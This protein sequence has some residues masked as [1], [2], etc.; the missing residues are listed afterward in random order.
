MLHISAPEMAKNKNK[1]T[2]K[3]VL[4]T[5]KCSSCSLLSAGAIGNFTATVAFCWRAPWLLIRD[6][7]IDGNG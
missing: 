6:G 5:V 7:K 2:V 1:K 4:K 3:F